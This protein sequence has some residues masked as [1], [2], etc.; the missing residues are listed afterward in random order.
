MKMYENIP[1]VPLEDSPDEF[2]LKCSEIVK[3]S[4]NNL[5]FAR[6]ISAMA[7][8]YHWT[9]FERMTVLAAYMT[10]AYVEQAEINSE[11]QL[12]KPIIVKM[13]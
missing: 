3:W 4:G 7:M 9:E 8:L 11:L 13:P 6:R 1:P 12:N 5:S 10:H 2:V